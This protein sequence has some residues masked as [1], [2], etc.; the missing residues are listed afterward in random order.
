MGRRVLMLVN[1]EKPGADDV[2]A[3]VHAA[4]ERFGT[5]V[6]EENAEWGELR[7]FGGDGGGEVDLVVVLGGDGTLMAQ[8]RRCLGLGVPLLGVNAGRV[9]FLA[10]F[11]ADA[12]EAQAEALFGDGELSLRRHPVLRAEVGGEVAGIAVNEAV[13]TAGPPYRM[14]ELCLRIDGEAGPKLSGDGLIVGTPMGSTAY[15]LSA[16]GPIMAPEVD[17][18][19]ITPIAAHSLAFR[20]IVVVG[21]SVVEL[22][23]LR[24]NAGNGEN[25][26][27]ALVLDGQVNRRLGEGDRVTIRREG[28]SVSFVRN[29]SASY[30]QTVIQKL[31]WAAPPRERD[32][33]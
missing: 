28:R 12:V 31:H 33:G 11:D 18:L 4:V 3:R 24:A 32:R 2:A 26:G 27:T 6:G 8:S 5:L 30:W 14:I 17:G 22:E 13:V 15:N 29:G 9:G 1:R 7:G 21:E 16:G 23:L 10:E 19:V 20:P 25:P